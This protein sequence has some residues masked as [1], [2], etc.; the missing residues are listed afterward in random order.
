M[1]PSPK[2]SVDSGSAQ[3][4]RS[5]PLKSFN[6][7]IKKLIR[8][9]NKGST[10]KGKAV[11]ETESTRPLIVSRDDSTVVDAYYASI[12][13]DDSWTAFSPLKKEKYARLVYKSNDG[14]PSSTT[15]KTSGTTVVVAAQDDI[16]I[17]Y[18]PSKSHKT[19]QD[20]TFMDYTGTPSKNNKTGLVS[21]LLEEANAAKETRKDESASDFNEIDKKDDRIKTL[22]HDKWRLQLQLEDA[23]EETMN[24]V[25]GCVDLVNEIDSLKDEKAIL[26]IENM[27]LRHENAKLDKSLNDTEGR[28]VAGDINPY[29]KEECRSSISS[30]NEKNLFACLFPFCF[31]KAD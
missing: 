16:V 8:S 17:D 9:G 18:T 21:S 25:E 14:A 12:I 19:D 2:F 7:S 27:L 15:F 30:G 22:V 3:A 10:S 31:P 28:S 24:V 6:Q 26:T 23:T 13:R 4:D 11:F 20:D 29:E 1:T 5:G